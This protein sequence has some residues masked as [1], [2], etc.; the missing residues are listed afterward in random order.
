MMWNDSTFLFTAYTGSAA[1][2]V[3]GLTVCKTA[4]LLKRTA[5]TEE[6]KRMWQDVLRLILDEFSIMCDD[7]LQIPDKRLREMSDRTKGVWWLFNHICR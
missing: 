5:L 6:D 7:Q 2:K 1:M 3:G 4:F